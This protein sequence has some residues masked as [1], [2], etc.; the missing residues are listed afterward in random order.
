MGVCRRV[1][2]SCAWG[3][4]AVEMGC[5]S[6]TFGM[7]HRGRLN[8][9]ANV[10]RKPMEEIFNEFMSGPVASD[11]TT[12]DVLGSGDVKYH[13]GMS[14]DRPTTCGKMVHL[15]LVAN[16]SHLETVNPVVLGKTRSLPFSLSRISFS[17]I[18][19]RCPT[20]KGF[21]QPFH[22][23]SILAAG[24][25]RVPRETTVLGRCMWVRA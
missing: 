11:D 25:H 10:M 7:P 1:V 20:S 2:S 23:T 14:I 15:S 3:R 21:V 18:L 24:C 12:G 17:H 16:P 19:S 22:P 8:I 9:L 6:I 5:E 4:R 13:L